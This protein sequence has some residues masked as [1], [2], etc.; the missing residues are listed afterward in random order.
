MAQPQLFAD[1]PLDFTPEPYRPSNRTEGDIFHAM[2]CARCADR[3]D[4]LIPHMVEA[5]D[6]DHESYPEEWIITPRGPRC[7]D[8]AEVQA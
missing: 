1:L 8:F 5:L 6:L 4:C 2:W 7:T 3:A